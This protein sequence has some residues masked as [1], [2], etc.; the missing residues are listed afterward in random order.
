MMM[1]SCVAVKYKN[2]FDAFSQIVKKEGVRSLFKRGAANILT[3]VAGAV[4]METNFKFFKVGSKIKV[5]FLKIWVSY[6]DMHLVDMYSS[7]QPNV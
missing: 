4:N 3:A 6:F 1:S 7:G 5:F 2:T